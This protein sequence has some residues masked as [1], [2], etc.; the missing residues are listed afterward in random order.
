[1]V[2]NQF[3]CVC[4]IVIST[5]FWICPKEIMNINFKWMEYGNIIKD[6]QLQGKIIRKNCSKTL[7][8]SKNVQNGDFRAFPIKF[9]VKIKT[10]QK[11]ES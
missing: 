1:M 3:K 4:H 8:L 7:F 2:G 6:N 9:S 5:L 10:K 11:L